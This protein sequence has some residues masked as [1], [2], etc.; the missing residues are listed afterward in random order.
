MTIRIRLAFLILAALLLFPC[1]ASCGSS[2]AEAETTPTV[3]DAPETTAA[4]ETAAPCTHSYAETEA[5]AAKAL[6]EGSRTM[7]C[8]LCGDSYTETIPATKSLKVL[9]IG[10]SF[11]VDGMEFLWQIAKNSGVETVVLGNLYIGGC[12]LDTHAGNIQKK[13][14]SYKYYKNTAGSWTTREST[15]VE[16]GLKDEDWDIVTVQQASGSSGIASTYSRLDYILEYIAE[17][18]PEAEIYW[19][20]TWA[21]QQDSTHK[22]FSKYGSSQTKMFDAILKTVNEQVKPKEAIVGIIP[23]GT[24]IQNLR[25][26]S[27]GDAVTR[28][29]YHLSHGLGRYTA[30]LTWFSYITG[31]SADTVEWF[32]ETYTLDIRPH[33]DA[34]KKAVN[35]AIASPESYLPP[36]APDP[37]LKQP[38]TDAEYLAAFGKNIEEY[39]LLDWALEVQAYYNTTSGSQYNVL[40]SRANSTAKNLPN[41]IASH[42]FTKE[43]LPVGSVILLDKGYEY[44]PE[45]WTSEKL[46]KNASSVRPAKVSSRAVEVTEE[47]WGNF[48]VRA[49]NLSRSPA[50]AVTEEDIAHMRI[51]VPK[52]AK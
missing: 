4:P 45:G 11:S 24:A 44:R 8:S 43:Q 3:T 29:G 48:A 47:W 28:D 52:T 36:R 22:E 20:M 32:P 27:V 23:A 39:E 31:A 14:A 40:I 10:N 19:H 21:Y 46:P 30:G 13:S 12:S 2:P 38:E 50:A 7:T 16:Y 35:D 6:T 49:F 33:L 34:V 42:K 18:R 15:T 51:Y 26:S 17:N 5:V 9:A 25:A 37:S 1:L 41:F